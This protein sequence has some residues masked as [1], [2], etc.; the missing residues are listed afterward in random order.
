MKIGNYSL[1]IRRLLIVI[2]AVTFLLWVIN[3][4]VFIFLDENTDRAP[5][6]IELIIPLGTSEKILAGEE[7]DSI[8][9]EMV[10]ILGD[11]LV[12]VNQDVAGHELGPLFVPPMSSASLKL[13]E[14][15]QYAISCSFRPTKYLGLI[16]KEPTNVL[17][18][19]EGLAY[20]VPSTVAVVFL[21]SLLVKPITTR[22]IGDVEE[23]L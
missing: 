14:A 12:L 18:R 5:Q 8:P 16:V 3:E 21:Y 4:S 15:D 10:F 13:D 22:K 9:D 23:V 19:L 6:R 17:T 20:T 11:V 2:A 7:V 1:Y